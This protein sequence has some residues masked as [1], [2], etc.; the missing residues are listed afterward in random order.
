LD[1]PIRVTCWVDGMIT[2]YTVNVCARL[3]FVVVNILH[4][5]GFQAV[6]ALAYRTI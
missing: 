6:T 4:S 5:H 1:R 3:N 2:K